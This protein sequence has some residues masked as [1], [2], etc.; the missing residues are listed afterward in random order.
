MQK[1]PTT[2]LDLLVFEKMNKGAVIL[3]SEKVKGQEHPLFRIIYMNPSYF[4]IYRLKQDKL[5]KGKF[6]LLK[7]LDTE[8]QKRLLQ[9]KQPGDS[10]RFEYF[11]PRLQS[12]QKLSIYCP[13]PTYF[14]ILIEDITQK[15]SLEQELIE[16]E[17]TLRLTLETAGEGLW[18]WHYS[19]DLIYHN[20]RWAQTLGLPEEST[21][22]GLDFFLN[23][24]H[25]DDI[26]RVTA[27]LDK[28]IKSEKIYFS[29]HRMV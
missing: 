24:V 26:E 7:Y 22:H 11:H 25:P 29:E 13:Q 5:P 14:A 18:Q 19:D 21:V 20:R 15:K 27:V 3:K 17:K 6:P 23:H 2:D 8:Q 12:W 16:S 1:V 9:L 10:T 28:A 4:E